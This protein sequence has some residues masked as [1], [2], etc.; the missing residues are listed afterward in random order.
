MK[1]KKV[2]KAASTAEKTA[3][4]ALKSAMS[5]I[6]LGTKALQKA[7]RAGRLETWKN[8]L[9]LAMQLVQVGM[10]A[11]AAAKGLRV[12]KAARPARASAKRAKRKVKRSR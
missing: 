8:R 9:G 12:G 6:R 11:V 10:F 3:E 5:S 1:M 2:K 4:R 7:E